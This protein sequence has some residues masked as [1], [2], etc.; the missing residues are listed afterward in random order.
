MSEK[1]TE[2]AHREEENPSF[3]KLRHGGKRLQ[4]ICARFPE[5]F[6]S[7]HSIP[8]FPPLDLF[9]AKPGKARHGHILEMVVR[10]FIA[11]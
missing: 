6:V 8:S 10:D 1:V 11:P 4:K 3:Q 9:V 2:L 5:I 7:D